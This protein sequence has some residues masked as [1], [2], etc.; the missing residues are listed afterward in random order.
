MGTLVH[1]FCQQ[2]AVIG[3]L[4]AHNNQRNPYF[5]AHTTGAIVNNVIYNPG[6]AAIQLG[7]SPGEWIGAKYL[8]RPPKCW[9]M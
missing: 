2:I 4:Y 6:S 1:N 5:K 3:N 9:T 7:F 8:P